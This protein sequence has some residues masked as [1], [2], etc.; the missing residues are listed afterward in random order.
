MP[1]GRLAP[2]A[3][4]GSIP[5]TTLLGALAPQTTAEVVEPFP[6]T[7][8]DDVTA[9]LRARPLAAILA[10][11]DEM[12]PLVRADARAI[13]NDAYFARWTPRRSS[14]WQ[15]QRPPT[16]SHFHDQAE[17]TQNFLYNCLDFVVGVAK[18]QYEQVGAERI[19]QEARAGRRAA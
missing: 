12:I 2:P 1:G 19:E 10:I 13:D 16:V 7:V 9:I 17:W 3:A 18:G 14:L 5:V 8:P 6:E 15:L 11:F 4:V